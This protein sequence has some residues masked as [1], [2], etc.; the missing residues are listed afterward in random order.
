MGWPMVHDTVALGKCI[1]NSSTPPHQIGK[2]TRGISSA[3]DSAFECFQEGWGQTQAWFQRPGMN[4][5]IETSTRSSLKDPGTFI[6]QA[7]GQLVP[8]SW[9]ALGL[10][11]M[12]DWPVSA[13]C[14]YDLSCS[15]VPLSYLPTRKPKASMQCCGLEDRKAIFFNCKNVTFIFT[16]VIQ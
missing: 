2:Q 12:N 11:P 6:P 3:Y 15:G 5:S 16:E 4:A 13:A 9:W 1:L 8:G 10:R 7:D 14:G